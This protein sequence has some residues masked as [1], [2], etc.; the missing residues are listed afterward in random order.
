MYAPRVTGRCRSRSASEKELR[1]FRSA[2]TQNAR[3]CVEVSTTTRT[4]RSSPSAAQAALTDRAI[5]VETAFMAFGR[6]SASS[7]TCPSAC[8]RTRTNS[9][10]RSSLMTPSG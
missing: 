4:S 2:P 7:A 5:A 9:P 6:S 3:S 10:N 1:S 8:R